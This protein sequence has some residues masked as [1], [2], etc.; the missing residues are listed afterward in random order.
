[1]GPPPSGI[2]LSHLALCLG[3]GSSELTMGEMWMLSRELELRVLLA[4]LITDA[5]PSSGEACVLL[6]TSLVDC[7]LATLLSPSVSLLLGVLPTCG[8]GILVGFPLCLSSLLGL[9][10]IGDVSG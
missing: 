2:V 7:V 1:M 9:A 5:S 4:Q 3:D 6:Y 8:A 10:W